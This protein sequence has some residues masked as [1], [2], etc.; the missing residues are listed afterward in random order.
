MANVGF[1]SE[2]LCNGILVVLS[3]IYFASAM[4]IFWLLPNCIWE[5]LIVQ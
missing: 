1:V 2:F 4:L 3:F 5:H